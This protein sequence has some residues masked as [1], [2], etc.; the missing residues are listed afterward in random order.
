MNQHKPHLGENVSPGVKTQTVHN[1]RNQIKV[2]TYNIIHGGNSRIAL[3][4]K[5]L[6]V[7]NINIG[8][9]TETKVS[10]GMYTKAAHG[11]TITATEARN[12]HQG[13]AALFYL[14]NNNQFTIE[15]TRSFGPNIIRTTLVSGTKRWTIIGC[16]FP[17]SETDLCTLDH[18][19]SAIHHDLNKEIILLDLNVN[20]Q[21]MTN[22]NNQQE[23]TAALLAA[24]GLQDL[25]Q[26]FIMRRNE[27]WTW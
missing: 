16:C 20:I 21:K 10:E 7:M 18:L 14:T 1:K 26:H 27:R 23:E 19:Q 11:Y 24:T 13:G 2:C 3:A 5:T 8:V 22:A 12:N 9:L 6:K 25:Q 15:G 17:L 4:I